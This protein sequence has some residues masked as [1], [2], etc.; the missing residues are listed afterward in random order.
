MEPGSGWC[1]DGQRRRDRRHVGM[2]DGKRQDE[3]EGAA[4]AW[5]GLDADIATVLARQL[6]RKVEADARAIDM[7]GLLILDS[8]EPVEQSRQVRSGDADSM[9]LPPGPGLAVRG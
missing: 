3:G 1:R 9:M 4:F 7:A 5:L 6:S 2:G 8:L